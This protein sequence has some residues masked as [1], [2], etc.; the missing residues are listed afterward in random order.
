M[1]TG[2]NTTL[3]CLIQGVSG[4]GLSRFWL[5][6]ARLGL[7]LFR[8]S[9]GSTLRASLRLFKSATSR[10]VTQSIAAAMDFTPEQRSAAPAR[11]QKPRSTMH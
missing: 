2:E 7:L 1:N 11:C 5:V 10:F 8:P 3:H 9:L 4:S 6:L